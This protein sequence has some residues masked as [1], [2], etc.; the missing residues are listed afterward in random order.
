MASA[1][2][3]ARL[4]V[5]SFG[6]DQIESVPEK[7]GLYAWY[8]ELAIPAADVDM[9]RDQ[10]ATA[11]SRDECREII[12]ECVQRLIFS[13]YA[14]T[15]YQVELKG[16]LKPRYRGTIP[17]NQHLDQNFLDSLADDANRIS[18]LAQALRSMTPYFASPIYIGVAK[19]SLKSRIKTH[20]KLI[21]EYRDQADRRP[22][23]DSMDADHSFAYDAM[24]LR[25][26][27]PTDLR[28]YVMPL[29]EAST[30]AMA[31][32]YVLNRINFPLCGRN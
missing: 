30:V 17:Y 7:P 27:R 6:L 32:E 12:T 10:L 11:T 16:P 25:K 15:D 3:R 26:F 23:L 24:I 20:R 1:R 29:G 5:Q 2:E 14:E 21:D 13:Q 28:V 9:C 4:R 19:N 8:H 31:A 22:A 18:H